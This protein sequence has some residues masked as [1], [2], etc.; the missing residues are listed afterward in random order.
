MT[1]S[2]SIN[3]R[4]GIEVR[5]EL[6]KNHCVILIQMT[7]AVAIAIRLTG[8]ELVPADTLLRAQRWAAATF[9]HAG[10]RVTW[11]SCGAGL[12]NDPCGAPAAPVVLSLQILP[13]IPLNVTADCMGYA[14]VPPT[15]A[16]FS[17]Y[18]AVSYP[19]VVAVAGQC[20]KSVPAVLGAAIAHEVGH[21]LLGPK[22]HSGG[23]M[24]PRLSCE[25][26]RR[27]SRGDLWFATDEAR[28]MRAN[29]ALRR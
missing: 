17:G 2:L 27:A 11:V 12:P 20:E 25:Q 15:G 16:G 19:Q 13:R 28:R 21:L 1:D 10:I 7:L 8:S 23:V 4:A 9:A 29:V 22:A 18:A 5:A 3:A 26:L 14:V 24:S 6:Q